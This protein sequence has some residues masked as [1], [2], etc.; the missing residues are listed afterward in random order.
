VTLSLAD[1]ALY[2]GAL[3]VLFLTPG[4]VWVAIVARGVTGGFRGAW[5]LAL[6]VGVGDVLWPLA[7]IFGLAWIVSAHAG[8]MEAMRWVAAGVFLVMGL[9]LIRSGGRLLEGDGRL[10]RPGLWAGFSA[11]LM[12]LI[13]NRKAILFYLGVLPGFF[14]L[15]RVT[16][17]DIAAICAISALVPLAAL[18]PLLVRLRRG[19][20]AAPSEPSIRLHVV[21]GLVVAGA[22]FLRTLLAVLALGSPQAIAAGELALGMGALAFLIILSHTG[23]GLQLRQPKLRRRGDKRRQ[24]VVTATLITLTIGLHAGL[25]MTANP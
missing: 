3:L 22:S 10:A 5:P 13:G 24:H 8:V 7:A 4:P 20:R 18:V 19:K 12:A 15:T 16:G 14:D 2:A 23:L 11:G 21:V 1:I 9:G 6:G 25:L 17:W